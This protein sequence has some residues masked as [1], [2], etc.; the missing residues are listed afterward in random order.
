MQK[1][2]DWIK[3]ILGAI[4]ES[5][6]ESSIE[7]SE[8]VDDIETLVSRWEDNETFD[9]SNINNALSELR[10]TLQEAVFKG[11]A[12]A[13]RDKIVN[14]INVPNGWKYW[15]PGETDGLYKDISFSKGDEI[16]QYKS[17]R[18][19]KE[20][21]VFEGSEGVELL[22]G[23]DEQLTWEMFRVQLDNNP[24][25]FF[26]S[27]PAWQIDLC[28]SVPALEKKL[29]HFEVSKRVRDSDRKKNNWQ[30]Q[31]NPANKDSISA[32]FDNEATF[33]ANPV[34]LHLPNNQYIDIETDETTSNSKI[35]ID[36]SF[37]NYPYLV[38]P[39]SFNERF[40][41]QRPFTI[42]DGQHRVRGA[43]NS[44]DSYNQ[45]ILV[46]V[47]PPSISENV[48]GRLFAEINTLSRP[49]NDKHRMFLAHRFKVSSP[50][51]KFTFGPWSAGNINT[52][53]DRANR[54]A[55][56]MAANILSESTSSFWNERIKFLN[57]NVKQQ[58]IIDVE[59]YVEFTY[60]W[61]LNYPYTISSPKNYT[62]EII[63]EEIDNYFSAWS[64][65]LGDN[66]NE[67][68]VDNCLFKSKTQSRVI[69]KRFEQVHIKASLIQAEGAIT[70]ETF[71]QVLSPLK[72]IPFT[73]ESILTQ[74]SSGLPEESWRHL[75]AWVKDAIE[76]G[77]TR[78]RE[79]ILDKDMRG[80]PGAGIISLPVDPETWHFEIEV[81]SDGLDPADGETRYLT[82][83]RPP[84]CGY[85]CRPE[86]WHNDEKLTT[87]ITVSA[88][89]VES[90]QNI[91]VRN[92]NPLPELD[93]NVR[94]RVVFSTI[95]GEAHKEV[96]IR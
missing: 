51:S 2:I 58:Q 6:R 44:A 31:L 11:K 63:F 54:M 46:V 21:S 34:I 86:I 70:T 67:S 96:D 19:T 24:S 66:W 40:E 69:L 1:A 4:P 36:L 73:H 23:H 83:R 81:G 35:S 84:N 89:K 28:S 41:D 88:K 60:D 27:V 43:A 75:D 56:E 85:T 59:K 52:H 16:V 9:T 30:R 78:S 42:I 7:I 91:P 92:R 94:L 38:N 12:T 80:I 61:F 32:F 71:C 25:I 93:G 14:M 29:S 18:I 76:E 15:I 87:Q 48:A 5:I 50:E 53:R 17:I 26:G 72:N 45:R 77:I 90:E 65:I 95:A 3:N 39:T 79:E 55:Y 13:T 20:L 74:F 22:K 33:F 8:R 47:L 68:K 62:S 64:A 82:V 49:L 57:E 10:S 37:A